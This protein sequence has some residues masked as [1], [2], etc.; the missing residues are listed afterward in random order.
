MAR[1]VAK[2]IKGDPKALKE[3]K[4]RLSRAYADDGFSDAEYQ[5][6]RDETNASLY[7][8]EN[9]NFL[10]LF[11]NLVKAADVRRHTATLEGATLEESSKLISPVLEQV[12]YEVMSACSE[13]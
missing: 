7:L 4:R 2:D 10:T 1:L 9:Y 12:G 8:T 6:Q 3:R 5:V 11:P 13:G